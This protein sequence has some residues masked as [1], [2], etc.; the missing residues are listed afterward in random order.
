MKKKSTKIS[1]EEEF[2]VDDI[3][4]EM[5]EKDPMIEV[6]KDQPNDSNIIPLVSLDPAEVIPLSEAQKYV[7]HSFIIYGYGI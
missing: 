6:L 4:E 7:A 1:P 3:P 2:S 5:E